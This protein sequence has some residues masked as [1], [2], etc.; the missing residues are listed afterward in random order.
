MKVRKRYEPDWK[1]ERS[2]RDPEAGKAKCEAEGR[3]RLCRRGVEHGV[4]PRW[5]GGNPFDALERHHLVPKGMGRTIGGDDLDDNIIPL[6]TLCHRAATEKLRWAL[7]AI[8]AVLLRDEHDYIIRKKGQWW[9]D[10]AYPRS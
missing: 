2:V 3:C 6:C 1:P 5:L 7:M 10:K 9:L 4:R 8:R